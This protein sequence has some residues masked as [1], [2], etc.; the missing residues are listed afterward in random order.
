M[1]VSVKTKPPGKMMHLKRDNISLDQTAFT[2]QDSLHEK[3]LKTL[4]TAMISFSPRERP[5]I[6]EVV[7]VLQSIAGKC[8]FFT[9]I[10]LFMSTAPL[11]GLGN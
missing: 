8:A 9:D 6:G 7:H 2:P 11:S 1:N 10:V 3:L 4:L 5:H